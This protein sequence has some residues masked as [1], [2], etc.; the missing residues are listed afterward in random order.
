[1]PEILTP[2]EVRERFGRMFSQRLITMVDDRTG[3]TRILEMCIAQGPIEWDAVNRLRAGGAIEKIEVHGNWLIMD[4]LPGNYKIR[5]GPVSSDTGGQALKSVAVNDG[6]VETS[7]VGLAGASIGVGACLPQAEGVLKTEY[8]NLPQLGGSSTVNV[9][10]FTP[11]LRHLVIGLD[12]TDSEERG[13]TW[14]L[15]LKLAREVPDSIFLQHKIVQL[16]HH[17][18]H[19][20]TNC[21]STAMSFAVRP[22]KIDGAI[23]F[24]KEYVKRESVSEQTALAAWVGLDPPDA[25]LE[26]GLRAKETILTIEDAEDAADRSGIAL[27]EI[28]GPRGKIGA[29]AAIG[30]FDLGLLS[31]GLPEDFSA[32][33]RQERK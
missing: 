16:N 19:K 28:T 22:D 8:D 15:G 9:K 23:E 12:D 18:P 26:F 31:A 1:M 27:H 2:E 13:A 5:F 33:E 30:C 4:A 21:T 17:A 24:T 29:L 32:G 20:T 25:V 10:I 6:I 11:E 7:W 14:E 3:K